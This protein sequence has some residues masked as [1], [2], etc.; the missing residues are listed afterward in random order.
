[1]MQGGLE[2]IPIP[3]ERTMSELEMR[4]MADIVR[5]IRVNGFS[6]AKADWQMQ[7]MIQ[8]GESEENIKQWI[9][10]ALEA[11]DEEIDHIFSDTVYEQYYGYQRAYGEVGR[12]Q[13]PFAENLELQVLLESVK[14]QTKAEFRNL[15]NSLGFVIRNPGTGKICYHPLMQFYR[16]TLDGAVMDIVSGAVSY[17]VAI[18]RAINAMTNSGLRT[19]YYDSGHSNR[20]EVAARRA[21]MTGFR[22]VQGKINEQAARNLGTDVY[23][24][25]YHV[26]ARPEHQVWQGKVYTYE[27]L[28]SVCGLG[29]VTGLHGANCYHDYHPFIPGV[30]VRNYTDEELDEMMEEENTPKEYQGKEYTAYQALQKQRLMERG[31]RKTRQD[32][33]LLLEGDADEDS[34]ILKKARYQ[35]EMQKYKAFSKAMKLPEQMPRVYQDGLGQVSAGGIHMKLSDTTDKWAKAAREEILKSEKSIR[36]RKHETMEVYSAS[37]K[38]IMTKRGDSNSVRMS[39]LDYKKLKDAVVTHNHPSGGSFSS[40]DIKFLKTMPISE[41]R[42]STDEGTYFIRKPKNWP[43]EINTRKKIE[44]VI[45]DIK[46]ELKPKYQKMYNRGEINRRQRHQMLINEVNQVFAE[47]YGLEYGRETYG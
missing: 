17:D 46:N 14:V 9:R 31:M 6:T 27:Q 10:E 41:L 16:E 5:S 30:S 36:N 3:L 39:I 28:Q 24:V 4:I 2:G 35:G 8:L 7:R 23:E 43:K 11:T 18:G 22:Q 26:G 21:V 19:V 44:E 37:G 20:V 45:S 1:M 29:S 42:V 34:I 38:Y 15:T 47:R 40:D 13:I 32:I 12:K 25:T 33:K